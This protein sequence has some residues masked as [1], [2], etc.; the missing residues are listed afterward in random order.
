MVWFLYIRVGVVKESLTVEILQHL[1]ESVVHILTLLK[2]RC[3]LQ[4]KEDNFYA[5]RSS[6]KFNSIRQ[7]IQEYLLEPLLVEEKRIIWLSQEVLETFKLD[8]QSDVFDLQHIVH[9]VSYFIQSLFYIDRRYVL[10]KLA[11]LKLRQ[12][13]KILNIEKHER[14]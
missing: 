9:N 5:A 6:D 10:G 1:V 2:S 14:A 12:G 7:E 8:F 4:L 3:C 11:L 13:E